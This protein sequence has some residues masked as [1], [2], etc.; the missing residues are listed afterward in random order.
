LGSITE[1][2]GFISGGDR[3]AQNPRPL[4]SYN[5]RGE[6]LNPKK[7]VLFIGEAVSL[8]HI[9]RPLVLAQS[10]D[11]QEYEIHFACDPRYES[12]LSVSPHIHYW[13]IQSVSAETF[14][15][16][17]DRG[18]FVLR[19]KDIESYIGQELALYKEVLPA[20]IVNDLRFTVSISAELSHIPYATLTNVHWSPYRVLGFDPSPKLVK[21]DRGMSLFGRFGQRKKADSLAPFNNT[22]RRFGLALYKDYY[23]LVTR[24]DYTL[25]TEPPDFIQTLSLPENHFFLG[26]ILWSPNNP[27]PAWWQTW[28]P[29]L[30]LIYLTLGSTGVARQLPQIVEALQGL[31]ITIVVAT[32]GRVQLQ[33]RPSNV[34]VADYLPGME[35]CRLASLV[36]CNGGS[37]TAYQALSQGTPVVGI[38]S[39][40]DQYLTMMVVE[41][42]G[43]GVCCSA[44]DHTPQ[45]IQHII[46][47]ALQNPDYRDG[48]AR[49]AESFR[50]YDARQRFQEFLHKIPALPTE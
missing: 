39:N 34:Y 21:R 18:G 17:A 29:K 6:W 3:A 9:T 27:K 43:A 20:L 45:E 49:M 11:P 4:W 30:P 40:T 8:A 1:E 33:A 42:A 23:D 47:S 37:A 12:L 7:R 26:P 15:R 2:R 22:R 31:P 32:A 38:W 25:Y 28:D 16:A 24:G 19:E 41:R 5:P 44:A 10:L 46:T 36:V 35:I 48:A 13:P 14:V 50:S